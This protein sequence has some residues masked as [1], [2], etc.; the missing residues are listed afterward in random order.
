MAEA[1]R[2]AV[3][4]AVAFLADAQMPDGAFRI[5]H[6]MTPSLEPA[7]DVG[8][9]FPAAVV[10]LA[11]Q[12]VGGVPA[13]LRQ[14]A[15]AHLLS[16]REPSGVVRYCDAPMV[17]DY[18]DICLVHTVLQH[19]GVNLDYCGVARRVAAALREDGF[20][21][22]WLGVDQ[23]PDLDPVVNVNVVRY[24]VRNGVDC[25]RTIAALAEVVSQWKPRAG[26][27]YYP[28]L[29]ALPWIVCTTPAELRVRILGR[30]R[31]TLRERLVGMTPQST[32]DLA[33][34]TF[35]LARL[36]GL[37]GLGGARLLESQ[38]SD[39]GWPA[40]VIFRGY[41]FW[42]SRELTTAVAVSALAAIEGV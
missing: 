38:A 4:R 19:A 37:G 1:I 5:G 13:R 31:I 42:G 6:S 15:I 32:L 28:P 10:L 20:F 12:R 30:S 34:R 22:T 36:G 3:R 9:P 21:P 11:L 7:E 39:G 29:G 26:T 17:P 40:E 35:A 41:G 23:P 33:M 25:T 16:R 24:L 18:D 27:R 14:R 8:S 2:E